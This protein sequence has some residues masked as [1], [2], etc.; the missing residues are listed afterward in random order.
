LDL[1][2]EPVVGT[3]DT[4]GKTVPARR[5]AS[6]TEKRYLDRRADQATHEP[7]RDVTK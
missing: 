1:L 4:T 2:D 3:V 6:L 7:G 5:S